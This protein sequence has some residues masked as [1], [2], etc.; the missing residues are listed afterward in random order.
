ME[1]FSH[2]KAKPLHEAQNTCVSNPATG[3]DATRRGLGSKH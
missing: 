1:R 2:V 3:R